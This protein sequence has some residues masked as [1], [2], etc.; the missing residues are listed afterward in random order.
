MWEGFHNTS[1]SDY[2]GMF[3]KAVDS[4]TRKG[5]AQKKQ[6]ERLGRAVLAHQEV[7][8]KGALGS[9]AEDQLGM[10]CHYLLFP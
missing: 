8:E 9:G 5:S 2:E 6:Q 1:S 3:M 10:S 4:E 7:R